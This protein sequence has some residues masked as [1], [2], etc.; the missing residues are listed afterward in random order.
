[1]SE[2]PPPIE[3][4]GE[5][6]GCS[7]LFQFRDRRLGR[8]CD[9]NLITEI[10][11]P[12]IGQ[13]RSLPRERLFRIQRFQRVD[14]KNTHRWI[15]VVESLDQRADRAL[16]PDLSEG[17]GHDRVDLLVLQQR[18]KNRDSSRIAKVSQ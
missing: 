12:L 3:L 11:L 2:P 4:L 10:G 17:P 8:L 7:D 18:D 1:M 5:R 13:Q 14:R 16:V 15:V 6:F 9:R